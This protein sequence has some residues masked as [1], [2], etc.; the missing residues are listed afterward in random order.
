ML[1]F[2]NPIALILIAGGLFLERQKIID[3]VKA[4]EY[5]FVQVDNLAQFL[6]LSEYHHPSCILLYVS[7]LD[8]N[9][10]SVL[11]FIQ[12]LD[13]PVILITDNLPE[14]Q[15]QYLLN[16]EIFTTIKANYNSFELRRNIE[17]ALHLDKQKKQE[18]QALNLNFAVGDME[19]SGKI[20]LH[21]LISNAIETAVMRMGEMIGCEIEAQIPHSEAL[22]PIILIKKLKKLLGSKPLAVAQLD[23]RGDFSGSAQMLFSQEASN[24]LVLNFEGEDLEPDELNQLKAELMTEV[25]NVAINS[26]IGSL[27]NALNYRVDYSVPVYQEGKAEEILDL[28]KGN[29][30]STIIFSRSHFKI[31]ELE[32]KGDFLFFF[33]ARLLLG[34]LFN[35]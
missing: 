31:P 13:I 35:V 16:Q 15:S 18:K 10:Q 19:T 24:A 4:K 27:S 7:F 25:G 22:Q 14:N 29:F 21:F 26:V 12:F 8:D 1:T 30:T 23:F 3:T 5:V 6:D 20:P 9:Y 32:T 2:T 34:M 33:E 11:Q 28:I 17:I